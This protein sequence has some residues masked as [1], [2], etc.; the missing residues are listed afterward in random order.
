MESHI[1]KI[2]SYEQLQNK[3][4]KAEQEMEALHKRLPRAKVHIL[5]PGEEFILKQDHIYFAHG[6]GDNKLMVLGAEGEYKDKNVLVDL[7]YVDDIDIVVTST[8]E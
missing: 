7:E 2:L 5:L 6:Y 3:V 4:L 1:V 8:Y